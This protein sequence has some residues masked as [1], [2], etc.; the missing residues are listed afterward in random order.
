[1]KSKIALGL[2]VCL[3]VAG[4]SAY[5]ISE[6]GIGQRAP[7]SV[8]NSE[9]D[10]IVAELRSL[11]TEKSLLVVEPKEGTVAH[12][13]VK[14]YAPIGK[15]KLLGKVKGIYARMKALRTA[16][17]SQ[18]FRPSSPLGYKLADFYETFEQYNLGTSGKSKKLKLDVIAGAIVVFDRDD[19]EMLELF[20][21][22]RSLLSDL[23]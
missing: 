21:Q 16:V 1:M 18:G 2:C 20:A 10:A 8:D 9:V 4:V 22:I 15:L 7:A 14:D 12:L 19:P 13:W 6:D 11:L 5:L 3:A 17:K 23:I